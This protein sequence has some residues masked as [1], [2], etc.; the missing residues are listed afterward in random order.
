MNKNFKRLYN[1]PEFTKTVGRSLSSCVKEGV[2]AQVMIGIFDY[3]LV[4]LALFLKATTPQIGVLASLPHLLSS[5]S[6]M[7]AIQA[8]NLAGSR[9][10]LLTRS[11]MLQLLFLLPIPFLT[12]A[13]GLPYKIELLIFFIIGFR[14]IGSLMGPAWGSIV[15]D[16]LPED[17]RGQYFGR[18]AQIISISGIL[19]IGVCGGI[20]AV[21]KPISE[22]LGLFLVFLIAA[23]CRCA[24][25]FFMNRMI[26]LP[27]AGS[28]AE[29][30][31][32]FWMFIRRFRQSNFV[33]FIIF[34]AAMT[35]ATQLSA[36][37]FSVYMLEDLKF[38]YMA[39]MSVHMAAILMNLISFPIWGQHADLI[40]NAK[41]LKLTSLLLP[42][43]PLLWIFNSSLPSLIMI[44]MFSGFIWGGFNLCMT[45]FIYDAVQPAKRVR[46]LCYFNMINSIALF[47][48]ASLGGILAAKLPALSPGKSPLLTLFLISAIC[49][50]AAHFILSPHFK[51]VRAT[52][53]HVN[54]PKLFMSVL[55]VRPLMGLNVEGGIYPILRRLLGKPAPTAS[56]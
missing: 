52:Y 48:G 39:Y 35:F 56:A 49:R 53:Q 20:L 17:L 37:Y 45:N 25:F 30:H 9:K 33:K 7:F 50:M 14:V 41:I 6:Q 26:E 31:F 19:G 28:P 46:C 10:K 15:S 2:A 55:G 54:S 40:G 29:A 16:Y 8:I 12:L 27:H 1:D 32:T 3:Y 18:R 23:L 22:G 13:A 5:L 36:A 43:S 4:P 51:E 38:G 21:M 47:A 42:I 24:S 11:I 34:A 44:E